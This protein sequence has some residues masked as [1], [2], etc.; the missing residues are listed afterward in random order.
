MSAKNRKTPS[1]TLG[2]GKEMPYIGLGT[3]RCDNS[4][5]LK[6]AVKEAVKAGYRHFDCAYS[7]LNEDVVGK[8]L[9]EC[10]DE[11]NGTLKREDLFITSKCWITFLEKD[12][13]KMCLEKTLEKSG[14]KY[15]DLVSKLMKVQ[16]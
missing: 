11:S 5:E 7:Y 6:Q 12:R 1:K 9:Q 13:M 16:L 14:F 2:N 4:E 15:L 3:F 8:A 10:Y